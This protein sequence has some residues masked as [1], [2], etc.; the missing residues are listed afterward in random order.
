MAN[1]LLDEVQKPTQEYSPFM[2]MDQA[3]G[4]FL[5]LADFIR[6]Q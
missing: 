1:M 4:H 3:S 6:T 5:S 2:L